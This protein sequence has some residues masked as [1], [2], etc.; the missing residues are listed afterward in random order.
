MSVIP[1]REALQQLE[2]QGLVTRQGVRGVVVTPSQPADARDRLDTLLV[3]ESQALRLAFPRLGE[4][5]IQRAR[6]LARE[7]E[8]N[9]EPIRAAELNRC[10]HETLY[11]PANRPLLLGLIRSFHTYSYL[12]AKAFITRRP[13]AFAQVHRIHHSLVDACAERDL[14]GALAALAEDLRLCTETVVA[15]LEEDR[16]RAS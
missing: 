6:R 8:R 1:L 4:K 5:T 11:A 3:L 13:D 14:A 10:F 12:F 2:S 9:H 16:P 7:H 15:I